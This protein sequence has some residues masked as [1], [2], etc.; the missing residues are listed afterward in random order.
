MSPSAAL[1]AARPRPIGIFPATSILTSD[2]RNEAASTARG[3]QPID[4]L[5]RQAEAL[6]ADIAQD[7]SLDDQRRDY[8][9]RH[10]TAMQ[11]SLRLL[12]GEVMPLAE[13]TSLLYDVTPQWVD[14]REF[15]DAHRHLDELLQPGASLFD[16]LNQRKQSSE[17]SYAQAEPLLPV[18]TVH[19]RG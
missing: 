3:P 18:I 12:H 8:L 19:L 4:D 6:A 14:E 1:C 2:R 10:V 9:A 15:E 13:E 17:M 16:R 11:T 7:R 5:A